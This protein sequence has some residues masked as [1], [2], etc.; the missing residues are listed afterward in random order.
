MHLYKNKKKIMISYDWIPLNWAYLLL[1]AICIFGCITN[2][3]SIAVLFNPKMKD[4]SFKY[5]LVTSISDLL[6]LF[7]CSY[8]FIQ[9][10]SDC[11]LFTSYFTQW[12]TIYIDSY[13]TSCLAVFVILTEITLSLL[14]YSILK[15]KTYIQSMKFYKVIAFLFLISLVFYLPVLFFNEIIPIQQ[16]NSTKTDYLTIMNSLGSSLYGTITPIVLSTIRI[17]LA[18]FVLTGINIMNAIE[19]RKRVSNRIQNQNIIESK[20]NLF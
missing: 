2:F 18:M 9:L 20:Y 17:I 10:C 15:N 16:I 13:L 11:P 3:F 12:Y 14:R 1:P 5:L 4:I 6:Y 19:F 7:L 8:L